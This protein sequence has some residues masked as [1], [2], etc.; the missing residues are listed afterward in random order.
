MHTVPL[1]NSPV[2]YKNGLTFCKDIDIESDL[3]IRL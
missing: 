2:G 3:L 1:I